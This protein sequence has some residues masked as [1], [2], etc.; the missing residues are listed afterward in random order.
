MWRSRI[1]SNSDIL[2]IATL[3]FVSLAMTNFFIPLPNRPEEISFCPVADIG[4]VG[5]QI[6]SEERKTV[7]GGTECDFVGMESEIKFLG[8]KILYFRNRRF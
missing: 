6:R 7:P 2:W 8:K 4:S 3:H 1:G 5:F